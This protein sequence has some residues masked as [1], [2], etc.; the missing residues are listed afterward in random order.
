MLDLLYWICAAF[1]VVKNSAPTILF[2]LILTLD[3]YIYTQK[4]I[5]AAPTA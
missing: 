1:F 3:V 5:L 2:S 4:L